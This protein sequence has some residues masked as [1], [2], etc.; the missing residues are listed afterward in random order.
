MFQSQTTVKLSFIFFKLQNLQ[1]LFD[2][3][4][5]EKIIEKELNVVSH[6]M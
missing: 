3:F 6:S 5:D 4:I 1:I 2:V